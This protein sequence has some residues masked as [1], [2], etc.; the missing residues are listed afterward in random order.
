MT[1]NH[2]ETAGVPKPSGW[3]EF[4]VK[5][6][7]W[8]VW[9][10][11]GIVILAYVFYLSGSS[12]SWIAVAPA[13]WSTFSQLGTQL[14]AN[15]IRYLALLGVFL[16]LFTIVVS[17]IGQKPKSFIPAFIFVFI[18]SA[19]I[20]VAGNWDQASRYNLEP[21]LVA[22]VLGLILSNVIGIPRWLDA[23][24]RVEFYIKLGIVLLGATLPFTLIIWAGPVAILQAS[25]VSLVTFFVIFFTAGKLGLD[26]RLAA[27]L[28]AGGAVCGVSAS[29]AV[30]GA[31]RA[32]KEHPPIAISL[33]VFYAIIL[34]F[35]L[36]LIARTLHLP[37]GVGGAWIGTSE[38]ADAAGLAAAQS[39]GGLAA[40]VHNGISGTADQALASYT[41]IKVIGR[42][43]WIGIWS[44]VL[45]LISVTVWERTETNSK[46]QAG[47]IWWRFPKFVIG[48]LI[49]SIL[50]TLIV[51]GN[52]LVDYNKLV[53]PALIAP[54]TSL[55]TW[56]FTFSF[57]SI[58][59]TTRFRELANAGFKPFLAFTFGVIVNVILGYILSVIVFGHYWS[60]IITH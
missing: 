54:I 60:S 16:V 46:V 6:D 44:F 40:D 35:A 19:I 58:G 29:I 4:W 23:G 52:T 18:L 10:G 49:A 25:I 21:P 22:L 48:F 30:A 17:F 11:L 42:D 39:Y 26:K 15:G 47:Q 50:T 55:R 37:T 36:P 27:V 28:G 41:L 33:V 20:Y 38:F 8:A 7:W 57:L 51:H 53:K 5:E 1:N 34:I 3:Q 12:I 32:K 13:K 45:A 14:S 31:V 2:T 24:F 9:L 59:L 43:M 56:A